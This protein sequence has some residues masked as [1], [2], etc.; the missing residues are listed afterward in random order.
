[1]YLSFSYTMRQ[2]G[3]SRKSSVEFFQ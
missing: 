2:V 3:D 1:M